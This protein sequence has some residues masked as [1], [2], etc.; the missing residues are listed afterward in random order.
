MIMIKPITGYYPL[1]QALIKEMLER[2]TVNEG[3]DIYVLYSL[4]QI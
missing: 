4:K 2:K 3:T 1:L